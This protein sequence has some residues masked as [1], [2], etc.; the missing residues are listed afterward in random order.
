MPFVYILRC[1]DRSLYVGQTDDM[2]SCEQTHNFGHGGHY[3]AA[4]RPVYLVYTEPS[5]SSE[6][7]SRRQRQLK[8]WT[9]KKKEALISGQPLTRT[10]LAK[11]RGSKL[12]GTA[13]S[14]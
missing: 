4:R 12:V 6:S 2:T 3:T 14:R 7:A 13:R 1:S 8:R 11:S 10:Q 9:T 5:E